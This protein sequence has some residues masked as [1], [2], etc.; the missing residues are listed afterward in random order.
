MISRIAATVSNCRACGACHFGSLLSTGSRRWL[1]K[2]RRY[3]ALYELPLE[4]HQICHF[5]EQGAG[6]HPAASGS[7]LKSDAEQATLQNEKS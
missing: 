2:C 7:F 1:L 5:A 3:A 4:F 6:V